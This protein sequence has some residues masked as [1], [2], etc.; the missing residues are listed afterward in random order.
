[1]L[2]L[3]WCALSLGGLSLHVDG[4]YLVKLVFILLSFGIG[5]EISAFVGIFCLFHAIFV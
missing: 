4:I 1:M 2:E 3:K 5:K